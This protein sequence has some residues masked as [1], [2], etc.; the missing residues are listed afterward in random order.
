MRLSSHILCRNI[1]PADE[2]D[3][4]LKQHLKKKINLAQALRTV[5]IPDSRKDILVVWGESGC[6]KKSL[7]RAVLSNPLLWQP[8]SDSGDCR[9]G[10][11]QDGSQIE[12]RIGSVGPSREPSQNEPPQCSVDGGAGT[13][14]SEEVAC[15]IGVKCLNPRS[16]ESE[17]KESRGGRKR[18]KK[19]AGNEGP[20]QSSLS[21]K[22]SF[23]DSESSLRKA[24]FKIVTETVTED[25]SPRDILDKYCKEPLDAGEESC[26]SAVQVCIL[27]L[28]I[29]DYGSTGSK[30]SNKQESSQASE[31]ETDDG[32]NPRLYNASKQEFV[33]DFL[34]SLLD[35]V[36][37][38]KNPGNGYRP[39][40]PVVVFRSDLPLPLAL[41]SFHSAPYNSNRSL[42]S[43]SL[44]SQ[45]YKERVEECS[46]HPITHVVLQAVLERALHDLCRRELVQGLSKPT[47]E[48]RSVSSNGLA[49]VDATPTPLPLDLLPLEI[50][51]PKT[52]RKGEEKRRRLFRKISEEVLGER[53]DF[54]LHSALNQLNLFLFSPLFAEERLVEL[55]A[56][57]C[58]DV[59]GGS[60]R[61]PKKPDWVEGTEQS[62]TASKMEKFKRHHIIEAVID[63]LYW[64]PVPDDSVNPGNTQD[65]GQ[66]T[67]SFGDYRRLWKVKLHKIP[68]ALNNPAD[69]PT[70]V[71]SS[72]NEERYHSL[73]P[74][75]RYMNDRRPYTRGKLQ[76]EARTGEGTTPTSAENLREGFCGRFARDPAALLEVLDSLAGSLALS[77]ATASDAAAVC[78]ILGESYTSREELEVWKTESLEAHERGFAVFSSFFLQLI[79]ASQNG[80]EPH[81][82]SYENLR[83][84]SYPVRMGGKRTTIQVYL[85]EIARLI[86]PPSSS[87]SYVSH[88]IQR[89]RG[90]GWLIESGA[91]SELLHMYEIDH[92]LAGDDGG[93]ASSGEFCEVKELGEALSKLREKL[94]SDAQN[95]ARAGE[96]LTRITERYL[97]RLTRCYPEWRVL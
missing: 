30:R 54:N 72:S 10:G 96:R 61:Q 95:E 9:I 21:R 43:S 26:T 86:F 46:V 28:I 73:D 80:R 15:E 34:E 76:S 87:P 58:D 53:P 57:A 93:L 4:L 70:E 85:T 91:V 33:K 32:E 7:I 82:K 59:D 79:Y 11:S 27:D 13:A 67:G 47:I 71:K 22:D 35:A 78:D 37:S 88:E 45:S 40:L 60:G 64:M 42:N 31:G 69:A 24:L 1:S 62:L 16:L 23:E 39:L 56:S 51:I 65:D 5:L 2:M 77:C 94:K 68:Q 66:G 18:S 83:R 8:S 90:T 14:P 3:A 44:F 25:I 63:C 38:Y 20:Y 49:G 55:W 6:G 17:S 29:D 97:P 19:G 84:G 12:S 92:V 41:R 36:T 48:L 50:R 75:F 74:P 81:F 89:R 52:S